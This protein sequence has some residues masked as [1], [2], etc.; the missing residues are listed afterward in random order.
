VDKGW[1]IADNREIGKQPTRRGIP[2]PDTANPN[3]NAE[4]GST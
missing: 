2:W 4:R 3:K 1:P